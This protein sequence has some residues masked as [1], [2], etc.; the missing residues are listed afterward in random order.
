L[1][2]TSCLVVC[3][4]VNFKDHEKKIQHTVYEQLKLFIAELE[5]GVTP[6]DLQ[7][8]SDLISVISSCALVLLRA[9]GTLWSPATREASGSCYLA[10]AAPRPQ[11]SGGQTVELLEER[12]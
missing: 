9:R 4:Y 10:V 12:I 1:T 8:Q 7:L 6:A 5:R 2:S 11:R 3:F